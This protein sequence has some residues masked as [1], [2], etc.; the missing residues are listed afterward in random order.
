M[1]G[2]EDSGRDFGILQTEGTGGERMDCAAAKGGIRKTNGQ[3]MDLQ[4]YM[5]LKIAL[6]QQ[7]SPPVLST[8]EFTVKVNTHQDIKVR[9][10]QR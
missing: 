1:E 9:G 8:S 7:V 6:P 5:R 2:E 4:D 10:R 3:S